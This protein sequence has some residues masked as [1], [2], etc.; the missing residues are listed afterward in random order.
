MND[1][2]KCDICLDFA[3]DAVETSCCHQVECK[4]CISSLDICPVCR[5]D[6]LYEPSYAIRRI[7]NNFPVTCSNEGCD[8]VTTRGSLQEHQMKCAFQS[9][10]CP[11]RDCKFKSNKECFANHIATEHIN[12]LM[13]NYQ[14]LFPEQINTDRIAIVPT[15]R[16]VAA[17]L[18]KTGKYYCGQNLQFNCSCCNGECGPGNGC[19]CRDCMRADVRARKLPRNWFVNREGFSCR[20]GETGR[21]YCGR[22]VMEGNYE[23]DGYCG[24]TDGPNCYSCQ[25]IDEQKDTRYAD[26]WV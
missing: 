8:V 19:N 11:A 10:L 18:G 4:E 25:R 26:V 7:I 1:E 5:A 9:F 21:F 13:L 16:G 23:C 3:N 6:L 2:L 22:R 14:A 20:R 24:P 15:S 12:Q 17:R